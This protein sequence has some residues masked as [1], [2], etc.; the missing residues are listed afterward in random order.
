MA[1][2]SQTAVR[3]ILTPAPELLPVLQGFVDRLAE[4]KGFAE[5]QRLT[6]KQGLEQACRRMV[7]AWQGD[8]ETELKLEFNAF[9][10][11]LEITIEGKNGSST[12]REDDLLLLNQFVD[13]VRVE[14]S[15]HGQRR[16]TL[17]KYRSRGSRR[18]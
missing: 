11:R 6:L 7:E 1:G 16:L 5:T 10:D 18:P 14:E 9:S 17:V 12:E 4:Q 15:G 2:D 3:M 13:R 8:P